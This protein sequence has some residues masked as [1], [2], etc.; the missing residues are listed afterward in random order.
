MS[1]RSRGVW[2]SG[3]S[4]P[5]DTAS[6][7]GSLPASMPH[8]TPAWMASI[9]GAAPYCSQNTSVIRSRSGE[10]FRYSQAG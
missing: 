4:G 3:R 1:I 9:S 6:S 8:S 7:P 2:I 10:S 5:M